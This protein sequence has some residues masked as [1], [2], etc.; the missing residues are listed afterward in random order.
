MKG[1][2]TYLNF[3]GNCRQAMEFYQ[4][5]FGAELFLMRYSEAPGD[6]PRE[7][8]D[9]VLH[10]TLSKGH[11]FLMGVDVV[12]GAPFQTGNNFS[13]LIHCESFQETAG[14]FTALG[15]NGKVTVPLQETFWAARY[16]MLTDQFGITWVFNL[17]KPGQSGPRP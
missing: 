14:L 12:P 15:E 9:R 4:R 2:I 17:E 1:V 6:W 11:A 16:G 13:V 7:A 8:G 10:S 3:D 5:C